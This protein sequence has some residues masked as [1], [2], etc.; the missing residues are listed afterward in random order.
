MTCRCRLR[1]FE[2]RGR[3]MKTNVTSRVFCKDSRANPIYDKSVV[4]GLP[5]C[6]G[7]GRSFRCRRDRFLV[8]EVAGLEQP[9]SSLTVDPPGALSAPALGDISS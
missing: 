1:N 7:C 2:H 4:R 9:E 5:C 3:I 8:L 6:D